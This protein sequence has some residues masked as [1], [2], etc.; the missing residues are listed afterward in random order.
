[1]LFRL[2]TLKESEADLAGFEPAIYSLG[3]YRPIH[4]RLQALWEENSLS[5]ISLLEFTIECVKNKTIDLCLFYLISL[6]SQYIFLTLSWFM[7]ILFGGL[8]S[9][10]LSIGGRKTILAYSAL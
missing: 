4:A 8:L 5:F 1:M 10:K 9:K 6:F 3:G 7:V 2:K